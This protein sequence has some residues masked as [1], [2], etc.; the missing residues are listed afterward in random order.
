MLNNVFNLNILFP[1]RCS[2]CA[3]WWPNATPRQ[4]RQCLPLER[5]ERKPQLIPG[6]KNRRW[7]FKTMKLR[8]NAAYYDLQCDKVIFMWN[9]GLYGAV[10]SV[11][12]ILVCLNWS[13]VYE[14]KIKN[15]CSCSIKMPRFA[16][17]G[18]EKIENLWPINIQ[19]FV[20]FSKK[21]KVNLWL[22]R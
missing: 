10:G 2:K 18:K 19:T 7:A 9:E 13:G 12:S 3:P 15:T 17:N 20:Q 22:N 1:H 11:L 8:V 4:L 16:E 14:C 6:H 5:R 21:K